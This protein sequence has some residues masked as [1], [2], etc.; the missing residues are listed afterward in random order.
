MSYTYYR[1]S[2]GYNT[3]YTF[4]FQPGSL[5]V[6]GGITVGLNYAQYDDNVYDP[7]ERLIKLYHDKWQF[8]NRLTLSFAWDGRDLIEN[9]SRGYYLSQS[10][11]YAGAS[12][13]HF[14][15]YIRTSS[16]ASG[17]LRCSF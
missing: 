6:G 12:S 8:S 11:T 1:I 2:L 17:Y 7:Y 5:N 14:P 13:G 9:T 16:S 4:M 10:F 15:N 3:G